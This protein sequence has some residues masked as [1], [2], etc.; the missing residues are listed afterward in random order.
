LED[1][2]TESANSFH[3]MSDILK[4]LNLSDHLLSEDKGLPDY[5]KALINNM[6]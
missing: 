5:D 6:E 1:D 4:K 3:K 2:D